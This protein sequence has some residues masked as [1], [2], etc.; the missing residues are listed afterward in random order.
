MAGNS[1]FGLNVTYLLVLVAISVG[2]LLLLYFA[3][4]AALKKLSSALQ[5]GEMEQYNK[6][7]ASWPYKLVL[8]R[9]T[10]ALLQL[11][12]AVYAGDDEAVWQAA[13]ALDGLKLRPEEKLH[14]Y[15]MAL[16]CAV[17]GHNAEQAHTYI[18]KLQQLLKG[19][20]DEKLQ[21]VL[22]DAE[23]LVAV[24]L[25]KDVSK[26][27]VLQALEEKQQGTRKGLT[28]YRL[29]KLYHFAKQDDAAEDCLASAAENLAGTAWHKVVLEAKKD[30]TVL[31]VK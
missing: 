23:L 3:Q 14:G 22:A 18:A 27:K 9:T 25:D 31:E 2:I 16:S 5:N 19:E 28:Q 6:L 24:Y 8:R 4:K 17:T 30:K 20:K 1:T 21:E 13:E 11:E 15:Q 29:A 26:I 7:L 12:G 10:V